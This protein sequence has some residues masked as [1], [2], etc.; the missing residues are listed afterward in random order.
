VTR[1]SRKKGKKGIKKNR[2]NEGG[3]AQINSSCF[4]EISDII[5]TIIIFRKFTWLDSFYPFREENY[6]G[7]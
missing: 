1:R 2:G 3:H 6:G 4:T 7:R 5:F